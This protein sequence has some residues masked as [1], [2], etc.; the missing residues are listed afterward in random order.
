M[1]SAQNLACIVGL[2]TEKSAF[3]DKRN[4]LHVTEH[5]CHV[6]TQNPS[7]SDDHTTFPDSES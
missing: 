1:N 4:A 5:P 6:S 3:S 2:T 7:L